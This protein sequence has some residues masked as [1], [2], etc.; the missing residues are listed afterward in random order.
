MK[1]MLALGVVVCMSVAILGQERDRSKVADK[2]KWNLADLYASEAAWRAEKDTIAA[3]VPRLRE[4]RCRGLVHRAGDSQGGGRNDRSIHRR[5]AAPEGLQLL[6]PRH[7]S[8][9]AAH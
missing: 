6:S 8:A 3:E 5:R 4:F 9:R 7:R 2:Y 1:P